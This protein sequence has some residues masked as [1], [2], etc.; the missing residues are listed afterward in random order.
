MFGTGTIQHNTAA[1]TLR[2]PTAHGPCKA[3]Y[4]TQASRGE[5]DLDPEV[6]HEHEG[7]TIT[8]K[9]DR[10]EV[11]NTSSTIEVSAES[12]IMSPD[13]KLATMRDPD[14]EAV[15]AVWGSLPDM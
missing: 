12:T 11:G 7:S 10:A 14:R 3:V 15:A 8:S 13:A 6:C 2:G 5:D 9:T 4:Q 1:G